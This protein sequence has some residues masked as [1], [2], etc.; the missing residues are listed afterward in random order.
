MLNGHGISIQPRVNQYLKSTHCFRESEKAYKCR[1]NL[2][3]LD[4]P[5]SFKERRQVECAEFIGRDF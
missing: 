5:A 3:D 4:A 1:L 2:Y